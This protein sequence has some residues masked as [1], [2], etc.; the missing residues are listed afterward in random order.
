MGKKGFKITEVVNWQIVEDCMNDK[1]ASG[2]KMALIEADKLLD[3]ALKNAGY[4]G[5]SIEERIDQAKPNFTNI[6]NLK[7][8][9]EKRNLV[10]DELQYNLN[11]IDVEEAVRWY[12]QALLDIE[13]NPEAKLNLIER[14]FAQIKYYIPSKKKFAAKV[15]GLFVFTVLF[16]EFLAKTGPGQKLASGFVSFSHFLF[17]W[18]LTVVLVVIAVVTIVT[19]SILYFE[20]RKKQDKQ[21][22]EL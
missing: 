4:P 6:K 15:L 13:G 3:N 18:V 12:H 11:S 14:V 8:A 10:L 17:K 5:K 16:V 20:K 9:R 1:T 22:F 7:K 2:Y 21:D 19:L